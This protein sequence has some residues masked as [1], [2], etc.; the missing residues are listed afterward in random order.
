MRRHCCLLGATVPNIVLDRACACVG[1]DT[2]ES[3]H[4]FG[5]NLVS[6]GGLICVRASALFRF[7]LEWESR[8]RRNVPFTAAEDK[9]IKRGKA[10][11]LSFAAI[12][13]NLPGAPCLF[14][15]R[16]SLRLRLCRVRSAVFSGSLPLWI[17]GRVGCSVGQ[18]WRKV[19]AP[20]TEAPAARIPVRGRLGR[21]GYWC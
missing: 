4:N 18:R 15:L 17:S 16:S 21:L 10:D 12:A 2:A 7:Q 9:L 14:A 6:G 19:L 1:A 5:L 11:G 20:K 8:R 3:L 13:A